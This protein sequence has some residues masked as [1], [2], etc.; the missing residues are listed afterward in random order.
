MRT[1][2]QGPTVFNVNGVDW[3]SFKTLNVFTHLAAATVYKFLGIK[4]FFYIRKVKVQ[5]L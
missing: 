5:F 2:T 1:L 3:T 4:E